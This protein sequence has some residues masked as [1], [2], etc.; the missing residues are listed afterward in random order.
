MAVRHRHD[1]IRVLAFLASSRARRSVFFAFIGFDVVAT[2]LLEETKNPLKNV[3]LGIG[4]GMLL[5]IVVCMLVAVVTT[6]MV[7]MP[8]S[9]SKT[10]P[11]WPPPS[12]WWAPTG[13]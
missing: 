10:A 5:I 12:N 9:P 7:S 13:P 4:V 8:I 6:G 3:P 2:R 1:P 11:R